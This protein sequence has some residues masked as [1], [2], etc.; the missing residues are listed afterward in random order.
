MGTAS[1]DVLMIALVLRASLRQLGESFAEFAGGIFQLPQEWGSPLRNDKP[2]YS[3]S[4][5]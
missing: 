5:S 1:I 2:I 3:V 4:R